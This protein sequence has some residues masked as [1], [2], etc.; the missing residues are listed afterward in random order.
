MSEFKW[1]GIKTP[2]EKFQESYIW[3]ITNSEHDSWWS[4]FSYTTSHGSPANHRLPI[5]QA[6]KA[7]EAIGYKCV[8]LKV[9][10]IGE[11]KNDE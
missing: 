9:T 6:I 1:Y 10:E 5:G 8:K 3:W 11:V 7:Y 4:F 2:D